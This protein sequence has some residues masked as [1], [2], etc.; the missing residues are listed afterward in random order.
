MNPAPIIPA[1]I[2][3][4]S[5]SRLRRAVSTIITIVPRL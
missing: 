1:L 2:G 3:F 4:P 5:A